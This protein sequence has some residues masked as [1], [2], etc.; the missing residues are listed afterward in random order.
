VVDQYL[1]AINR[2][3]ADR[4]DSDDGEDG[5]DEGASAR[6]GSGEIKVTGLTFHDERGREQKFLSSARPGT[7]R[8]TYEAATE[9]PAVTFGLGFTHESGVQVAGPNSGYGDETFAV[10]AGTGHVDFH[11][12]SLLLQPG[13]F[14]VTTAAVDKGHTYDYRDRAFTL[15]VRAEDVVTEPGLVSLPGSW[16]LVADES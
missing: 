9:L 2:R 8:M 10:A 15:K 14:R 3:E 13:E 12:P 1:S 6:L 7:V 5:E 16:T 11:T 4:T